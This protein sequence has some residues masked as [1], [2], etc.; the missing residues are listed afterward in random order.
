VRELYKRKNKRTGEFSEVWWC[1]FH[2]PRLGRTVRRSTKCRDRSAAR[3]ARQHFER[4]AQDPARAAED[5]APPSVE[6]I[7]ENF[8]NDGLFNVADATASFYEQKVAH[9]ARL[10][11]SR[12]VTD[13]KDV[14]VIKGFIKQ[15]QTEG[16]AQST[17]YKELVA[18]RQALHGAHED[19][20]IDFDPRACFPRFRAKGRVGDRWLT[21]E[22][23]IKLLLAFALWREGDDAAHNRQGAPHRQMWLVMAVLTGGNDSE[24]DNAK[25]EDVDW[26]NHRL[27][28]RGT[29]R[30]ARDRWVPMVP[31]L[32]AVL[33]RSRQAAG[34]IVGEWGNIRRDIHAACDR[35]QISRCSPN[36]LRRTFAT[37]M[38][39]MGVA[40]N[41]LVALMGHTSSK[42][43]RKVYAKL[44]PT[45]LAREMAKLTGGVPAGVPV[46]CPSGTDMTV[47]SEESLRKV[48]EILENPVLGPGIEPGTRGF[49]IRAPFNKY[50]KLDRKKRERPA[51]VRGAG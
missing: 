42:M 13:L 19:G 43:I 22:E 8:I 5:K 16:A 31:A 28:L 17:I 49:S 33:R 46:S 18:L 3:L 4:T 50:D 10:L 24:V 23:F 9:P 14:S 48:F 41:V 45:L 7:L 2:D 32:A 20:L 29:K 6:S 15:R 40:E 30:E 39:N 12:P 36:D 26:P 37:W 35:A 27:R 21:P 38:A 11:G 1:E 34:Y 44:Q 51:G 47:V 25:W